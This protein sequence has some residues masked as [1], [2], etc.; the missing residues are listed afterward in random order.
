M[1]V[2]LFY[3][4]LTVFAVSI[5]GATAGVG[6]ISGKAAVNWRSIRWI[7]LGWIIT[8]PVVATFS[9]LL[10]AIIAYGPHV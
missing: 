6:L 7:A 1:N 2:S 5:T 10:T 4:E 3:M 8:I 9:G